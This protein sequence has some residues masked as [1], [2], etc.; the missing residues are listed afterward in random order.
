LMKRQVGQMNTKVSQHTALLFC[1]TISHN[2]EANPGC[3]CD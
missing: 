2:L 1:I 3:E